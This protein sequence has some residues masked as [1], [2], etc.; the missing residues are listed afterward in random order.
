MLD[1]ESS[2]N[3][4]GLVAAAIGLAAA[5]VGLCREL[6]ITKKTEA[7]PKGRGTIIWF[8]IVILSFAIISVVLLYSW[9]SDRLLNASLESHDPLVFRNL[10]RERYRVSRF[11][12]SRS[13]LHDESNFSHVLDETNR[14]STYRRQ[15]HMRL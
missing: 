2:L 15:A 12:P 7:E 11:F 3:T 9:R 14:H 13:I 1:Q 4:T 10:T 6:A 5:L 8:A